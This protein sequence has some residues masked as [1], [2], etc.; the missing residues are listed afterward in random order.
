MTDPMRAYFGSVAFAI[1]DVSTRAISPEGEVIG[2]LGK[3]LTMAE[4]PPPLRPFFHELVAIG[5]AAKELEEED[6]A[7]AIKYVVAGQNPPPTRMERVKTML[8]RGIGAER[9]SANGRSSVEGKA[10][11]FSNR[12]NALALGLTRLKPF[13]DRQGHVF[14]ILA[15]I[16][17]S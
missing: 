16:G 7:I 5:R 14:K 4:C 11:A 15:G 3:R 1:V 2:V 17:K 9:E 8:E 10:V 13:Q 6:N 12:I